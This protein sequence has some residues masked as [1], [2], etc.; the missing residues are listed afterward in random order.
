[1]RIV[2]AGVSGQVGSRLKTVLSSDHDIIGYDIQ[3]LDITDFSA[4]KRAIT[5]LKPDIVINAA[6][7]TDVDGC[8]K[9]PQRAIAVNAI[10]AQNLAIAAYDVNASILQ[11]SSNEVFAGDAKRPY[12]EYDHRSAVNPYGHSKLVGE[13]AVAQ[14]NPRHYIVRFSWL[15]AHGGHN[16]IHAILN[17]AR[18]GKSLRVVVDEVSN[19]TYNTDLVDALV[20]LIQTGRYGTYHLPNEGA[21]SRYTFARYLLDKAG[22]DDVP[23]APISRHEWH[24]PSTPPLYTGLQNTFARQLGITMRSWESAVDTFLE[25]EN[26]LAPVQKNSH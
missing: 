11:L 14:T 24:R 2:I 12:G 26:L 17:A 19:P 15:F 5:P 21:I 25:A 20:A 8:A 10:G 22:F 4:V 18:A 9:D 7:W 13:R 3:T 23:I 16:F 6:A 1:M